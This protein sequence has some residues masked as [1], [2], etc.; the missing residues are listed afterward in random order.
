MIAELDGNDWLFGDAD[1]DVL[2]GG[3]GNDRLFGGAGADSLNGGAGNDQLTDSYDIDLMSGGTEADRLI[4]T[5]LDEFFGV[6]GAGLDRITD[7]QNGIDLIDLSAMDAPVQSGRG[8][9]VQFYRH[10]G[11]TIVSIGFNT[12]TALD[13]IQ[14]DGVYVLTAADFAL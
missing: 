4:F 7:F 2:T 6:V 11:N 14:L 12:P 1:N 13:V 9:G 8:S 5:D 10:G 3:N